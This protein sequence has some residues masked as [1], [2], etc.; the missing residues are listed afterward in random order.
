MAETKHKERQRQLRHDPLFQRH[1]V[2]YARDM[3]SGGELS[4]FFLRRTLF[5]FRVDLLFS[6][7]KSRN[8]VPP[9]TIVASAHPWDEIT[10]TK[11]NVTSQST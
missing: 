6:K 4:G 9:F 5:F 2:E 11:P 10:T 1:E 3:Q 7:Q 8:F